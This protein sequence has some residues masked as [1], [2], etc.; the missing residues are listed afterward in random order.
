[1]C[2]LICIRRYDGSMVVAANR[3]ERRD[4]PSDAPAR[5]NT[6]PPILAGTDRVAGGSWLAVSASGVVAAVTNRHGAGA[7]DPDRPSRGELPVLASAASDA[8]AGV[9]A[10]Q[11][12]LAERT[13]NPFTLLVAD[14]ESAWVF[15]GA[16]ERY[17]LRPIFTGIHIVGNDG[18]DADDDPRVARARALL[19]RAP[20]EVEPLID[21]LAEV[22]ADTKPL[23]SAAPLCVDAGA[24]GT[25]S[26]TLL[27][28]DADRRLRRYLH[29]PG[30]PSRT[31]YE[32]IDPT[33]PAG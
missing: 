9:R 11:A 24:A 15:Q 29:A 18:F 13:F 28:V 25:V 27:Y 31:E 7:V 4:R 6:A 2:L 20:A 16:D 12:R 19:D 23:A 17:T 14:S 33:L 30:P 26:S 21:R 3:D 32:P 5:W 10:V 22:C 8:V 1:M